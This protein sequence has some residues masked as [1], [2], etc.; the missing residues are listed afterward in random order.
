MNDNAFLI[1]VLGTGSSWVF[2]N[3]IVG[4]MAGALTCVY[5]V[6]RLYRLWKNKNEI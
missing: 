2:A 5:M 6:W 4:T 3:S 1:G